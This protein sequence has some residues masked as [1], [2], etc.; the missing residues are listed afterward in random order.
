MFFKRS[1]GGET[2]Q[3]LKKCLL[4]LNML[5]SNLAA[6]TVDFD[7][8]AT[9]G[10]SVKAGSMIEIPALVDGRPFPSARW[11]RNDVILLPDQR[12]TVDLVEKVSTLRVLG[13]RSN[14][15]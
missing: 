14:I 15:Y 13:V 12:V 8:R 7:E 10:V 3:S 9:G 1:G 11:S 2:S 5:L 4:F 6:P